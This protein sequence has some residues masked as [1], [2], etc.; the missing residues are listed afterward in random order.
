MQP[1]MLHQHHLNF[2]GCFTGSCILRPAVLVIGCVCEG[3][4]SQRYATNYLR[5]VDCHFN[6]DTFEEDLY[7]TA[8]IF[9]DSYFNDGNAEGCYFTIDNAEDCLFNH[10]QGAVASKV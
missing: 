2:S 8:V 10:D 4:R 1:S 7:L 6:V 9:E 3:L 5:F